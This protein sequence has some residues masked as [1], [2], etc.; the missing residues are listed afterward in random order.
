MNTTTINPADTPIDD[1]VKLPPADSPAAPLVPTEPIAV[2]NDT[3]N[4]DPPPD[5]V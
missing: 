4:G 1:T 3:G 5:Q 2:T